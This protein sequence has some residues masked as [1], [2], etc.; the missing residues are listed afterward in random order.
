M[1]TPDRMSVSEAREALEKAGYE[2]RLHVVRKTKNHFI[3][4]LTIP[5]GALTAKLRIEDHAVSRA[6]VMALVEREK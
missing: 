2:L 4:V 3:L 1:T 5:W 6:E